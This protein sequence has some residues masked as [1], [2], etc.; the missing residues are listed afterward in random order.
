MHRALALGNT[1]LSRLKQGFNSPRERHQIKGLVGVCDAALWQWTTRWTSPSGIFTPKS[2]ELISRCADPPPATPD[3]KRGRGRISL[4]QNFRYVT[5]VVP[6]V[7]RWLRRREFGDWIDQATKG[8]P[9][10]ASS[11]DCRLSPLPSGS[12]FGCSA[13][14]LGRVKKSLTFLL[15]S[16]AGHGGHCGL[17]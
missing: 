11:T 16:D 2:V 14:S 3:M 1:A 10:R 9:M 8:G 4:R 15:C 13:F 12:A 7:A 17:E 6:D 5:L